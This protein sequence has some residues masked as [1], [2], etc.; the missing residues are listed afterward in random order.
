VPAGEERG[1]VARCLAHEEEAWRELYDRFGSLCREIVRSSFRRACLHTCDADV[2]D[3]A[4]DF[5]AYLAEG[6]GRRLGLYRAEGPLR[7]YVAVLA[8]NFAHARAKEIARRHLRERPVDSLDDHASREARSPEVLDL[9]EAR[10]RL[11]SVLTQLSSEDRLLFELVFRD[12]A[13]VEATSRIL[14]VSINAVY[15]RKT[16]LKER[17]RRLLSQGEVTR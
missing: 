1:L 12:S 9:T 7:H 5:F 4:A 13:D 16:R 10:A 3:A 17:L 11:E 8:S 6:E 2:E 14:H 15:V